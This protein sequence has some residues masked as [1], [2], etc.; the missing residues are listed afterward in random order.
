LSGVV[1]D[2]FRISHKNTKSPNDTKE[3]FLCFGVLV[4][5]IFKNMIKNRERFL[6][7]VFLFCIGMQVSMYSQP[8]INVIP[9]PAKVKYGSGNF[10]L[11]GQ[12]QVLVSS[13]DEEIMKLAGYFSERVCL[14]GKPIKDPGNPGSP[15]IVFRI[16]KEGKLP[17]E[18]YSLKITKSRITLAGGSG[19]G[20]FYGIQTLLQLLPEE[21]AVPEALKTASRMEVPCLDITDN[22]RFPYRGMH[23][24]VSRHFFSKEFVKKYIDLLAMYKMNTFH[25]HL[26]DD[27]GW[28]IEI[29]KYP[30]LTQIGAWRVDREELPWGDRPPQ[31]PG[32]KATYGGF[33]SQDDIREVVRYAQERYITIIPEIEMPA[34]SREVLAAYPQFSCTGGPFTVPPGSYWPNSDI[35]CAGNDS[36]FI[37]LQDVLA[38][39]MQLFPSKCI[40]VGGDEA[41][42]TEWKKC[43]KCQARMKSEGL[44]DEK[45]LQSYFMSRM[46]KFI[47][48][49]DHKMIGWDEILEGGLAP[50]ATVMSWRGVEGGIA[51]ARQGHD[52]IMTPT[53]YCYFDYYQADPDFEPKAIGGYVPLKKVY[54]FEPVPKELNKAESRFI[55]GAQGNLWTEFIPT[56]QQAE[57]MA[58]PRMIALAEVD[59]T[60]AE[61]KDWTSFRIRL[62]DQF[63]RLDKMQVNYSKGSFR[64]DI[65]TSFDKKSNVLKV[66]MES[67]QPG[68]PIYYTLDAKDP[69]IKSSSY[70][71]P[72]AIKQNCYIKA[73]I[74]LDGKLKEKCSER[75]ILYHK[76]VG[77][78]V[79][80]SQ[81]Y[82][83]RYTAG[84]DGA[85]TDGMRGTSNH[86]D[87]TWQ[88]YLGNGMDVIID[89]GKIDS[90]MSVSAAF[91]Q[92]AASWIFMPDTVV[93]SL[94]RDGKRFHSINEIPNDIPK[95][96]DRPI[97]KQ[98]SQGFPMTKARYIKVRA[99]NPGVCPPWHEGAGEACWIF[100]DEIVV[101]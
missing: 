12:T 25:W 63:K 3:L 66:K 1:P 101:Y 54:S 55:L 91:L 80:Y 50:D 46:G 77:K 41:D 75:S 53:N 21:T 86:R 15:S 4:A 29:K 90:I 98:F 2:K 62:N 17:A 72:F 20:L 87:G 30:K 88:G 9:L 74:F 65:T 52:V 97:I 43:P 38:E 78:K 34:H 93:I 71:D 28:R 47:S 95:K 44:K 32:E 68:L 96:T 60:P 64:V 19:A 11:T 70:A 99:V 42:K 59:W 22:P 51:A 89:L 40:H 16:E 79:T 7:F 85:L 13:E 5:L 69:T 10:V 27:N 31:Q 61:M 35:L 24:D 100:T 23:L 81:P 84:G 6:A 36:T 83:Y 8:K 73:G 67:E 92:V 33:Y 58:L 26:T 76:A 48:S 37:F 82:S 14:I 56:S 39:V 18:G 49:K 94:S 57:Y 45:E